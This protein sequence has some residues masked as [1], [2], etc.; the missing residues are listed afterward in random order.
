MAGDHAVGIDDRRAHP[1]LGR[2]GLVTLRKRVGGDDADRP[3][4]AMAGVGDFRADQQSAQIVG[5]VRAGDL[6]EKAQ[7]SARRRGG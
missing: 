5:Q 4:V 2:G 7:P 1:E 3:T 6:A